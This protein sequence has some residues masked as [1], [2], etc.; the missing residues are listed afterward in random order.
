MS[1]DVVS[2]TVSNFVKNPDNILLASKFISFTV[3]DILEKELRKRI[4]NING[5]VLKQY[6]AVRTYWNQGI[7]KYDNLS[8]IANNVYNDMEFDPIDLTYLTCELDLKLC[9]MVISWYL[10]SPQ[11]YL[12]GL[13]KYL[14]F[15]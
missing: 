8:F 4:R 10:S 3:T 11:Q 14:K 13:N 1:L 9:N 6:D 7:S 5:V 12:Y 15:N 2:D